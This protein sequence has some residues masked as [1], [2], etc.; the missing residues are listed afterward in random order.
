[1]RNDNELEVEA[2]TPQSM[3]V[4]GDISQLPKVAI[5][6]SKLKSMSVTE[7]LRFIGSEFYNSDLSGFAKGAIMHK[8]LDYTIGAFSKNSPALSQFARAAHVLVNMFEI[9]SVLHGLVS[10]IDDTEEDDAKHDNK[11][12]E[13]TVAKVLNVKYFNREECGVYAWD[14]ENEGLSQSISMSD[15]IHCLAETVPE[16]AEKYRYKALY[17]EDFEEGESKYCLYVFTVNDVTYGLSA[18][19]PAKETWFS[20]RMYCL[21]STIHDWQAHRSTLE[22]LAAMAK[23]NFIRI[24]NPEKNMLEMGD[25]SIKILP[26][27]KTYDNIPNLPVDKVRK[28]IAHALE[29][30]TRRVIAL[31][32]DP[33]LGKTNA[34]YALVNSFPKIPT[35]IVSSA[36][37]GYDG[38]PSNVRAVFNAVSA[39]DSILVIDDFDGFD[40]SEKDK[41]TTEFLVQ[42]E[43]GRGFKGVA[44]LIINDPSRVDPTIMNRPGRVDEV[45]KIDYLSKPCDIVTVIKA[46]DQEADIAEQDTSVHYMIEHRFSTARIAGA[47]NYARI[48]FGAVNGETL[49]RG[50]EMALLFE[51]NALMTVHKGKLV[52]ETDASVEKRS[53]KPVT[54]KSKR[55]KKTPGRVVF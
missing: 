20:Q 8:L 29:T 18:R 52:T 55:R 40:V 19:G 53:N 2:G 10:V 47:V 7:R 28:S 6:Q 42:L 44:I 35:F 39:I 5:K 38:S 11:R 1:M 4:K 14:D 36:A 34:M 48:H 13:R 43:G 45:W 3:N 32:G 9:D 23:E 30:H 49:Q 54:V 22:T 46:T 17:C 26:R 15:I 51:Q 27:Q 21:Y 16:V 41:T 33:G 25:R 12:I 37:M 31:I 50:A 24:V